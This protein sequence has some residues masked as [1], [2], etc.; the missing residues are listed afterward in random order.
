M[1]P[2]AFGVGRVDFFLVFMTILLVFSGSIVV[3][4]FPLTVVFSATESGVASQY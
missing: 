4:R 2:A 3:F 1:F